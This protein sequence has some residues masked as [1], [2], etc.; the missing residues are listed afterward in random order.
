MDNLQKNKAFVLD[1]FNAI[2]GKVKTAEVIDR[3]MNDDELKEHI[4]FFDTIF[5][6]YELF[7]DEITAENNRVIVLARLKGRHEGEMNGIPP[8][9]KDVDFKFAIGYIIEKGLIV[10]HWMIA[11]QATMMEQLGIK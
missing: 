5:P 2:S 10:D 9:Y 8:T 7:A 1:Y 6:E 4:I 3:Y 11:D